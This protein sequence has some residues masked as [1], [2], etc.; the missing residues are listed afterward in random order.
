MQWNSIAGKLKTTRVVA[1]FDGIVANVAAHAG[2]LAQ[3]GDIACRVISPQQMDVEFRVMETDLSRFAIGTPL[4]IVPVGD[5]HTA[6]DAKVTEVNP[7][8]DEQGTILL[9]AR[10]TSASPHR[11]FDGMHVTVLLNTPQS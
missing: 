8:V 10:V 6:Y 1:P 5:E 3:V 11:L 9:R 7:I 4:Q 2:Q